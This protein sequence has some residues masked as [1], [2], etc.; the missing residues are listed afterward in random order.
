[1]LNSTKIGLQKYQIRP[2]VVTLLMLAC[3]FNSGCASPTHNSRTFLRDLKTPAPSVVNGIEI[4]VDGVYNDRM[5]I[6]LTSV[7]MPSGISGTAKNVYGRDL[8]FVMLEF[9]VV[10]ESGTKVASAYANTG[11]LR[12]DAVWRFDAVITAT[13]QRKIVYSEI[14]LDKVQIN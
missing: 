11:T 9:G 7:T 13:I 12:K 10:D 14:T 1:M 2:T 5:Q 3:L 6:G 8:Q 4:V